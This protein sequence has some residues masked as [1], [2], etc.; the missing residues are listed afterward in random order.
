MG[1]GA[2]DV[3]KI[4]TAPRCSMSSVIISRENELD[5]IYTFWRPSNRAEIILQRSLSRQS[6]WVVRVTGAR[7]DIYMNF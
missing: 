1:L 5:M 4:A 3:H 6:W 7:V 2:Q